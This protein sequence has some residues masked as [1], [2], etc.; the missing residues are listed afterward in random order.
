MSVERAVDLCAWLVREQNVYMGKA[1]NIAAN[2]YKVPRSDV[3]R[4]MAA[5]SGRSQAGK[6]RAPRPVR[7]CFNCSDRE[8]VWHATCIWAFSPTHYY[9]CAE[10]GKNL[11]SH[12]GHHWDSVKWTKYTPTKQEAVS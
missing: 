12:T 5:R 11:P 1:L 7:M 4:G 10:C 8:A 9:T 6:K 3:Q 2:K